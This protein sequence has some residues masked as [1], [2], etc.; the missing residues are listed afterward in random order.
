MLFSMRIYCS[1]SVPPS[2][3]ILYPC[4]WGNKIWL[5]P[6]GSADPKLPNFVS[7]FLNS[8]SSWNYTLSKIGKQFFHPPAAVFGYKRRTRANK[9]FWD[10]LWLPN[11]CPGPV[12]IFEPFDWFLGY[13]IAFSYLYVE[14]LRVRR[15]RD[16]TYRTCDDTHRD[17]ITNNVIRVK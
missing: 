14:E 1:K 5:I 4:V 16:F 13:K 3:A 15:K 11:I 7:D 10:T 2:K 12:Q 17:H 8:S 6:A 9:K